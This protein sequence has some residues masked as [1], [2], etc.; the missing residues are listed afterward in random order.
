[1]DTWACGYTD[2]SV[3]GFASPLMCNLKAGCQRWHDFHLRKNPDYQNISYD[4]NKKMF[5]L[6]LPKNL[7]VSH[8][9]GK[10]VIKKKTR[11]QDTLN[12]VGF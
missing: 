7:E 12:T 2:N 8:L 10:G 11:L 3:E 5:N 1:M 4:S 6:N 9:S